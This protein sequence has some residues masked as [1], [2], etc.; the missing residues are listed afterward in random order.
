MKI[1]KKYKIGFIGAKNTTLECLSQFINDGFRVD[2]LITLTPK[3]GVE[4]NVAGYYDLSEFARSANIN[5]YIPEKYSLKND[6]DIEKI[7]AMELDLLITIGWQRLIPSEI[8][9]SLK[10]GACGMHGSAW[11]LPRGRGRSPLNW[12]LIQGKKQFITSLFMYRPGA[13]DGGI[14]ESQIFDINDYDNC[15]TLHF[16]NRIALN[17]LLKNN[18]VDLL[19][20]KKEL[21]EQ[22]GDIISYYPQRKP[23][24]AAIDWNL[25]TEEIYN[26]IRAQTRPFS[27][28]FTFMGEDK[29]HLWRAQPFDTKLDYS[30]AKPGEVVEY[31]YN[32]NFVVKTGTDSILITD[33]STIKKLKK[34]DV[35]NSVDTD[36]AMQQIVKRYPSFLEDSQKEIK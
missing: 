15:E 35:F 18:I 28:A 17:R 12:S 8:L 33:F 9:S 27:G 21:Q 25:S 36:Y 34:G 26:F 4:N 19:A 13:D 14:I 2:H 32:D 31:F 3:Q 20:K 5:I 11:G 22:A 1:D 24:D 16:K 23:E 29:I 10:V 7:K 30:L 6:F